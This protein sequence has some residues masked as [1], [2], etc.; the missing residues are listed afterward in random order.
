M[1]GAWLLDWVAGLFLIGATIMVHALGLVV[2]S[3]LLEGRVARMKRGRLKLGRVIFKATLL[4]GISGWCLAIL[5]GLDA[6]LWAC[7]YVLL[8]AIP[9]F[10]AATLYSVD[11]MATLGS[12]SVPVAANWSLLGSLEAA[13][14]MLLFGVSTAFL[15]TVMAHVRQKLVAAEQTAIRP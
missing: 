13:N 15:F 2:I 11:C 8:G 6:G 3:L 12:V 5:H 4:I 9:S 7:A 10:Q 14:G 1:T